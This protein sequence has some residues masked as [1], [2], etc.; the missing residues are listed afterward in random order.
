MKTE[1]KTYNTQPA[2]TVKVLTEIS[3]PLRNGKKHVLGLF[4]TK[5]VKRLPTRKN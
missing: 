2:A 3:A 4:E 1:P 5:I